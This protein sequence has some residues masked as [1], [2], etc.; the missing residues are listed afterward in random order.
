[1][2]TISEI[3]IK[4]STTAGA[5][6]LTTDLAVGELGLNTE[7]GYLYAKNNA[8]TVVQAIG[9]TAS[10]IK[11]T[12]SG[13]ISD[14]DVQAAIN[15]LDGRVT[16]NTTDVSTNTTNIATNTSDITIA[17]KGFVTP[18]D[19]GA[20]GDGTT[21]DTAA[22]T[23]AIASGNPIYLI[24]G[25]NITASKTF[26]N[27]VV[28]GPDA[29]I[30][31]AS[32]ITLT[33]NKTFQ[34]Y[35][36]HYF[37]GSV[38][39]VFTSALQTA[40]YPEWWGAVVGDTGTDCQSA[41]AAGHA[42]LHKMQLQEGTYYINS[43]VQFNTSNHKV[44]GAGMPYVNS[45]GT[46]INIQSSTA[47]AIRI[48]DT[49]DPGGINSFP[50][51]VELYDLG[52]DRNVAVT[53]PASGSE[54]SA[55]SGIFVDYAL[56]VRMRRVS[57]SNNS[58]GFNVNN[59]VASYFDECTTARFQN[60]N[61]ATNDIYWGIFTNSTGTYG[62]QSVYFTRCTSWANPIAQ[63]SKYGLSTVGQFTDIQVVGFE[64]DAHDI[65][66]LIDGTGAG[67]P[68]I[69]NLIFGC[70]L[71]QC[72]SYGIQIQNQPANSCFKI[73]DNYVI[74]KVGAT[75]AYSI[76][77]SGSVATLAGNEANG[78]TGTSAI[79]FNYISAAS[80]QS[81]GNTATECK[82]PIKIST[83]CV[84]C[85]DQIYNATQVGTDAVVLVGAYYCTIAPI[86]NGASGSWTNGVNVDSASHYSE[87]RTNGINYAPITNIL[88]YNGAKVTS[89]GNFGS[90]GYNLASGT[91][92]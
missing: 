9:S 85:Q 83:Q 60:G 27:T 28:A 80:I 57:V 14:T 72:N 39:A 50:S 52:T 21:D 23:S 89:L 38:S 30:T 71:D 18:E 10:R 59:V 8:G 31:S 35:L 78:L 56:N 81:L 22:F 32:A 91:H 13:A 29:Y 87:V 2:A 53:P 41:L 5:A 90:P 17:K 70:V 61:S 62:L 15:S 46:I 42:A 49:T 3:L 47:H 4:R 63:G 1:M 69:D 43:T 44:V 16:T 11:N 19:Y 33:F 12:P 67:K 88:Y 66:M 86:I 7:D 54:A 65:G 74:C 37:R 20:V 48:G 26:T 68:S 25:Y 64:A 73:T 40:G 55:P 84:N 51:G 45:G 24:N 76:D 36:S 34:G 82:N 92:I 58:I 77:I 6:P 75:A 79:G